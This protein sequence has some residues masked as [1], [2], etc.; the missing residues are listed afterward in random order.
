MIFHHIGL[1]TA[2]LAKG[3]EKL[4]SIIPISNVSEQIVDDGMKVIIQFCTDSSGVC[5][6]LV[7]PFGEGN[8]V[9]G[10]LSSGKAIL[11]HVAYT[12][13]DIDASSR[14]LRSGGCIPIGKAR[15]AVAFQNR[16]VAFFLTPLHFIIELIE[17]GNE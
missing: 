4:S 13:D 1:F 7:A 9:S 14:K 16:K 10:V 5:Y 2:D 17:S 11:N 15:P 6:E 8:P 12:V 3:R